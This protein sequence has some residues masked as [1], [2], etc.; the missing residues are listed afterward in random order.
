M[1]DYMPSLRL[2]WIG[3]FQPKISELRKRL[4][5]LQNQELSLEETEEQVYLQELIEKKQKKNR[6]YANKYKKRKN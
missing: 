2:K 1:R 3:S 6:N 5:Y 4:I